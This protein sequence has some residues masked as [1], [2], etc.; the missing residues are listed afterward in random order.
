[1]IILIIIFTKLILLICS[2]L[3]LNINLVWFFITVTESDQYRVKAAFLV[4]CSTCM[5]LVAVI[6]LAAVDALDEGADKDEHGN[7]HHH[8]K[9]RQIFHLDLKQCQD[10]ISFIVNLISILIHNI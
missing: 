2:F 4:P 9:L 3:V 5:L 1:M 6:L 10:I 8:V 7:M